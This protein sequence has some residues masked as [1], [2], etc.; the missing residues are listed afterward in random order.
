MLLIRTETIRTCVSHL[1]KRRADDISIE[2]II[3][4]PPKTI[5][6]R[7]PRPGRV[8]YSYLRTRLKQENL[9]LTQNQLLILTRKNIFTSEKQQCCCF[10]KVTTWF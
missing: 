1:R 7:E 5:S 8:L 3:V 4:F 10:F 6:V 2:T 9:I